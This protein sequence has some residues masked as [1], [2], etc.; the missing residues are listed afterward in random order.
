LAAADFDPAL[1]PGLAGEGHRAA[2]SLP[3]ELIGRYRARSLLAE[4]LAGDR[5]FVAGSFHAT[6]GTGRF[7]P[8]PGVRV[9]RFKPYFH[10]AAAAALS[11]LD[12]PFVF[13]ID[14]N[15]PRSETL[16]TVTFHRNGGRLGDAQVGVLMG[17]APVHRG[18][19]LL[20]AHMTAMKGT[21]ASANVLAVTYR[22]H[23]GGD[24]GRRRFDSIWASPDFALAGFETHYEPALS[25][26]TD[27]ALLIADLGL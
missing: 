18:R 7:G 12:A 25:A 19:D 10:A 8:K 26:G 24:A 6:P 11:R 5:T 4:L 9:G 1:F 3:A 21:P 14:A 23:N 22:T 2:P 20:R 27:H 17:L 16:E 13:A 15:E